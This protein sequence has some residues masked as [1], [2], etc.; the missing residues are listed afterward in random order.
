M[1]EPIC[2]PATPL[3]PS[4]VAVVRVSGQALADVLSPLL[5]LPGARIAA[6]RRLSWDGYRERALV[7]H[8]PAPASYTGE[9]V[10]EFQLH[11]NPLL[12]RR[13][14]AHLGRL[15]VRLA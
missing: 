6:L 11:G 1:S 3:F 5:K 15:G 2:A 13:F 8:F 10:V 9:D 12:V 4:A 14:L 7:I